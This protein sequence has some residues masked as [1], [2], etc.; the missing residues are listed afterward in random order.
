MTKTVQI[1]LFQINDVY[2]M[3]AAHSR[4]RGGLSR[5]Q[6]VIKNLQQENP[7]TLKILAG[8]M[9]GPSVIGNANYQGRPIAG[10]QMV[11]I[12]NA[13]DWDYFVLGNHE[14]D[15]A[16][17]DMRMRCSEAEF[18]II[19]DNVLD[20]NDQPFANTHTDVRI[21]IDGVKIGIIGITLDTF[22]NRYAHIEDPVEKAKKMAKQLKKDGMDIILAITH[23]AVTEDLVLA[24]EAPEI[25]II[26][27]GHEHEN[28]YLKRGENLTPIT[29]ADANAK[30]AFIH[31][32]Y[33]DRESE[34][35]EIVSELIPIDNKIAK[36]PAIEAKL[37]AWAR[38]AFDSLEQQGYRLEEVICMNTD[39]LDGTEF[40]V[41]TRPSKLTKLATK[42]FYNAYEEAD[43]AIMNGGA[44]RID[45]R[46]IP[47]PITQYDIMKISP[48]GDSISLAMMNGKTLIRALEQGAANVG[49][50][51]YLHYHNIEKIDGIWRLKGQPIQDTKEYKIA[52]TS[53]MV[54]FGD[55]NLEFLAYEHGLTQELPQPKH[56]FIRV[57]IEQFRREYP[58]AEV[59]QFDIATP[60]KI[61]QMP[62]VFEAPQTKSA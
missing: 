33:Y 8:D 5:V 32:L 20:A 6:T 12:L 52:L 41:R 62:I 50:G 47:G 56:D 40:A 48:F 26:M 57:V 15:L 30:T 3:A 55:T 23:Q 10:R 27:G 13:M 34:E 58:P 2:E 46:L 44:V 35:L 59:A 11:D 28:Y 51:S 60:L 38:I 31:N 42:A 37:N 14:L 25:D 43:A 7:N 22:E 16:E 18:T 53:Y 49:I 1:T 19:T 45:D 4:S 21:E 17:E 29:K 9:F 39:V 54:E 36:D 61:T 24:L